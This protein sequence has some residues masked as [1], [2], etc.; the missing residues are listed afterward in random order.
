MD[1]VN[2][3][4]IL[5][6]LGY[7]LKDCGKEYRA[8]PL[9][10]D[11]DNDTVLKIY[12]DTG[13]W[14]DF[15]ENISGDF[16]SLV[17]MTLKLEDPNKAKEWLKDKNF[18]FKNP[19][20][21]KKPLIKSSKNFDIEILSRLE[22]NQDYWIKREVDI[23][24]LKTFKGG[25][26]K[27]GK[28]K[29]RYVFPIFNSKNNIVG[30]SGRDITNLSKIKWKHIGEKTEFV[31]P[32]FVNSE[33]IQ[34]QKEIILVE[35]IGDMLSLWQAGVKNTLVTFGTSLSLAILNYSL[36]VD[37]KKIYIS[38]N[39]DSNKNNAGNIAAEKTQAR[40]SRYFDQSQLKIA[41]PP[42]KDFGEMTKEE[43]VQWK[44][45]L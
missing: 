43:I 3:Y 14:F 24:T 18:A 38:L 15:K 29:N 19:T 34:E 13:H 2:V 9:Y 40:L 30:F 28:M 16:S 27:M 33:I 36:K 17:G 42:K 21:V 35:S 39:N 5:T 11:S 41:L 32:L 10:R 12:K 25:L 1:Q 37:L 6:D 8:R 23:Q 45:N 20:E 26:A 44:N 22:D 7:K 4:Q 31:Y